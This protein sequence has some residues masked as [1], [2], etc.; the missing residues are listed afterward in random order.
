MR[1]MCSCAVLSMIILISCKT[2]PKEKAQT[3]DNSKV[4]FYPVKQFLDSQLVDV[5]KTPYFIYALRTAENKTD[6][7][8]ISAQQ[9]LAYAKEFT[10]HDIADS[11]VK[12]YYKENAF[13]DADIQGITFNYMS[14]NPE[15]PIRSV[16][17]LTDENAQQVKRIFISKHY[18]QNDTT[19]D[20]KMGWTP[21][22]RFFIN[23]TI[24]FPEMKPRSQQ[25]VVVWNDKK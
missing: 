13:H 24:S 4:E 5:A 19:Y 9:F 2:E 20:L 21:D 14:S 1:Y 16:D 11:S 7:S 15:L 22:E 8:A 23:K 12:K 3:Y 25:L 18:R 6:S 17:V 10:A